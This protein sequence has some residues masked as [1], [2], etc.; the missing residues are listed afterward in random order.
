MWTLV[1]TG[2]VL[3]L[4]ALSLESGTVAYFSVLT[5]KMALAGWMFFIVQTRRGQRAQSQGRATLLRRLA[6]TL[7]HINMTVALGIAVFVIS[8]ILRFLVQ[9]SL[10]T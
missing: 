7:G 5:T 8:D 10:E 4:D 2:G 1:L 3:A 6:H 9:R